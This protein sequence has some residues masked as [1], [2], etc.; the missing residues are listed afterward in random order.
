MFEIEVLID[1]CCWIYVEYMILDMC[2]ISIYPKY[3]N[4]LMLYINIYNI[5]T[6]WE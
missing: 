1:F 2:Y 5:T 6:V 4:V 3:R